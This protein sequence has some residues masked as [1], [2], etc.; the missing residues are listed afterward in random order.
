MQGTWLRP[1]KTRTAV[2]F[3]HGIL[4]SGETCWATA[5]GSS[6]PELLRDEPH[7]EQLG[8]YVYTY[9]TDIFSGHYKL[10]DVV[11]DF[12]ERARLDG[13]LDNEQLIFVCHSMGGVV[14][15]KFIVQQAVDLIK[16]QIEIGLFLV[17]S[18][19]LGSS[20]ANL[21]ASLA[22]VFGN[23]QAQALR[24]AG[25]NT[26]LNDLDTEFQNIKEAGAL[27][28]KGKELIEDK[29]IVLKKLFRFRPVV[30]RLS[31]A[32]YFGEVYKVPHADHFSIAKPANRDAIQ[33]RLLCKFIG[34]IAQ[35]ALKVSTNADAI[36]ASHR[37]DIPDTEIKGSVDSEAVTL[38]SDFV[39]SIL[40]Q[41]KVNVTDLV[42]LRRA[43]E[44]YLE[45]YVRRYGWVKVLGMD[46]PMPL[47][48]LYTDVTFVSNEY[49]RD[50]STPEA[51]MRSFRQKPIRG[52]T[53]NYMRREDGIQIA[54][55]RPFL[56]VLGQPGAGKS[57]FLRRI[58]YE[59]LLPEESKWDRPLETWGRTL[60]R[61]Y[62]PRCIPVFIEL[63]RFKGTPVN[64][65]G[66]LTAEFSACGFPQTFAQHAL[67]YGGLL[68]LLDGL[69]EVPS[70]VADAVIE[71]IREFSHR[72][73]KNRFITSCRVAFYRSG[74]FDRFKDVLLPEFTPS[75]IKGFTE[76]WF[77]AKGGSRQ[78]EKLWQLLNEAPHQA[79]LELASTPLLLTF[80]CLVYDASGSLPT[81][82]ND[83][84]AEA[85]D[86]LLEKWAQERRIHR[87]SLP[88]QF[89]TATETL[90]LEYIAGKTFVQNKLFFSARDLSRQIDQFIQRQINGLAPLDPKKILFEIEIQ[91]GLLVRRA[92]N[93]FSFS[94]LTLHEFLAAR[95]FAT[96]E[97]LRT[98]IDT[99][100]FDP[101]W[102]ELL[103]MV[104]GLCEPIEIFS[105][106]FGHIQSRSSNH[107][108][109][110]QLFA[111][112]KSAITTS[113]LLDLDAARRATVCLLSQALNWDAPLLDHRYF[114]EMTR[115]FVA[116]LLGDDVS[117]RRQLTTLIDTFDWLLV[118]YGAA[119][120]NGIDFFA[121]WH[122]DR[123]WMIEKNLV[124]EYLR[125]RTVFDVG[126]VNTFGLQADGETVRYIVTR[127]RE[128]T[129]ISEGHALSAQGRIDQFLDKHSVTNQT[130]SR[131]ALVK[132]LWREVALGLDIP[133]VDDTFTS[134]ETKALRDYFYGSLLAV[135]CRDAAS[136][137]TPTVGWQQYIP[138]LFAA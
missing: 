13:V 86:I 128:C 87:Q 71:E 126:K 123:N 39:I 79:T 28:I 103:L 35:P 61:R 19:S 11:D 54:N 114:V 89:T 26:W 137:K 53:P 132:Q 3:V 134:D 127:C 107:Q 136:S 119:L 69:D 46:E 8:I 21:L 73:D 10:S 72:Y 2:I 124:P 66:A 115:A 81:D 100:L 51:L 15:R 52:L 102:R 85:L 37:T 7:L 104:S 129:V 130:A 77:A 118:C 30:E 135:E 99:Q 34:Q 76:K 60:G 117:A 93:I 110:S 45:T 122:H 109:L 9:E 17:A 20:Y 108:K 6:W 80:I 22:R 24:F 33:H 25:D 5:T 1:P 125:L 121:T 57:T 14:V 105:V 38:L 4:S 74:W 58:G 88:E 47:D 133:S 120:K 32:R 49:L 56:N 23:S 92:Q 40:G 44:R 96:A 18:P 91:Q 83:L 36:S 82:R 55:E 116:T 131:V 68:L 112:A 63:K 50:A 106:I 29:F 97:N 48:S 67:E 111:W 90:L 59:S 42:Q 113:N 138:S 31:G 95:Y 27:K 98:I 94:H 43:S 12:K 78:P 62:K 75:Q 41:A 101:H 70:E 65:S 64:L 16:R 84:Y